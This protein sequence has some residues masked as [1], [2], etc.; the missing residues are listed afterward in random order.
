MVM[1]CRV[2]GK[3][4]MHVCVQDYLTVH[5]THNE[6]MVTKFRM[7]VYRDFEIPKSNF[8]GFLIIF[9]AFVKDNATMSSIWYFENHVSYFV[10]NR[11]K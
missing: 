3:I 4:R 2:Q 6:S 10:Q 11:R 8:K 7:R 1:Q 9:V 5:P